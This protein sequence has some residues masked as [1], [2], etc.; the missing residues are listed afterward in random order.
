MTIK[1]SLGQFLKYVGLDL[2]I[3]SYFSHGYLYI[4]FFQLTYNS[5]LHIIGLNTIEFDKNH[6]I[7]NVMWR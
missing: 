7:A 6:K 3:C 1:K 2:Q 5:N 4:A